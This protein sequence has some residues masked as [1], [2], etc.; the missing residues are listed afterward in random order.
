MIRQRKPPVEATKERLSVAVGR[1]A[2]E[3]RVDEEITQTSLIA[4]ITR[5]FRIVPP[6]IMNET[7]VV[8]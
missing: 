7:P 5:N 4:T 2:V 6:G 3:N 1:V 8:S